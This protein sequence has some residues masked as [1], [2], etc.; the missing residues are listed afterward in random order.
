LGEP[1][2][3]MAVRR[4]ALFQAREDIADFGE[5]IERQVKIH[6][7]IAQARLFECQR[8]QREVERIPGDLPEIRMPAL[9]GPQPGILQLLVTP[10]RGQLVDAVPE[11]IA[12]ALGRSGKIEQRSIGVEDAGLHADERCVAHAT[13]LTYA[14]LRWL[15][16]Q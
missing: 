1:F 2:D 11:H 3:R 7:A 13:Y 12:A 4:P 8:L 14:H 10:E 5:C 6:Q 15:T 9:D 16:V